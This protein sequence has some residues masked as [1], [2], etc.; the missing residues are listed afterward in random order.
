[1]TSPVAVAD[2]V[3]SEEQVSVQ[4]ARLLLPVRF[5]QI[6]VTRAMEAREREAQ[7]APLVP[8]ERS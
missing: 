5:K 1:M 4:R 2:Q 3:T 7:P 6:R 8:T